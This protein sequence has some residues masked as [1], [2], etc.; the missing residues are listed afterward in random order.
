[1][2]LNVEK[3]IR[4]VRPVEAVQVT[5]DNLQE[6]ADWC[7]GLV[8]P[9]GSIVGQ[10]N[11]EPYVFV[12][13]RN[14]RNDADKQAFPTMWV[15]R[16]DFRNNRIVTNK[17]FKNSYGPVEKRQPATTGVPPQSASAAMRKVGSK[18]VPT[19]QQVGA[20][21]VVPGTPAPNDSSGLT[22]GRKSEVVA[23]GAPSVENT[24]EAAAAAGIISAEDAVA[25]RSEVA[26]IRD[27]AAHDIVA[28]DVAQAEVDGDMVQLGVPVAVN[29]LADVPLCDECGSQAPGNVCSNNPQHIV[30]SS[31]Q[32]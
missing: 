31:A 2:S 17:Q 22:T 29:P 3:F 26:E 20:V 19:P 24:I 5:M 8:V 11:T 27:E 7:G 25:E 13:V 9:P 6:V 23:E 32:L 10:N 16:E 14:P 1:M 30:N 21:E 12:N 15:I 28:R 4:K 18:V